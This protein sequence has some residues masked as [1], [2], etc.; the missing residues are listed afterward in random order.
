MAIFL[1]YETK[2]ST[3][4]LEKLG[5]EVAVLIFDFWEDLPDPIGVFSDLSKASDYVYHD[6]LIRKL[7][8]Y[9]VTDQDF[10]SHIGEVEFEEFMLMDPLRMILLSN[11]FDFKGMC[12]CV[13]KSY[14]KLQT[15]SL[16]NNHI[17]DTL[18]EGL[19]KHVVHNVQHR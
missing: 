7:H 12:R 1:C 3:H 17:P 11:Y 9:G 19:H 10:S 16:T 14:R 2:K 4:F 15:N 8:H 18:I 13:F 6:T 5:S